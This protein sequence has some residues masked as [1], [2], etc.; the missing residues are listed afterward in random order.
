MRNNKTTSEHPSWINKMLPEESERS[1]VVVPQVKDQPCAQ[2]T[3]VLIRNDGSSHAN[4]LFQQDYL[5][6]CIKQKLAE[7]FHLCFFCFRRL[8]QTQTG[9]GETHFFFVFLFSLFAFCIIHFNSDNDGATSALSSPVK[10]K[11]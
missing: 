8:Y 9:S 6:F 4:I 5:S 7:N 3:V 2:L 1:S 10:V 11:L